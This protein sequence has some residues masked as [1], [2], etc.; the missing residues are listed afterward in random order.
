MDKKKYVK[1]FLFK[2][3][4]IKNFLRKRIQKT[5]PKIFTSNY[6]ITPNH[7]IRFSSSSSSLNLTTLR[8]QVLN[9]SYLSS[10]HPP[11]YLLLLSAIQLFV[12]G[13][14]S[15]FYRSFLDWRRRGSSLMIV[16]N[17]KNFSS[18]IIWVSQTPSKKIAR[19]MP[20][21]LYNCC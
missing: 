13:S 4:K 5:H 21:H 18:K 10:N 14:C 2:S 6:L 9:A 11:H 7:R 15:S 16:H 17:I 8:C 12:L 20:S 3:L 19:P 1:M